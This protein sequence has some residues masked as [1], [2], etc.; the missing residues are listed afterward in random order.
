MSGMMKIFLYEVKGRKSIV[1]TIQRIHGLPMEERVHRVSDCDMKMEEFHEQN[2]GGSNVFF[3]DFCKHR[4]SGPGRAK[5]DEKT[6]G[7]DLADDEAFGEMTAALYDPETH[8]VVVQY[9]HYGPRA[10]GIADYF[11]MFQQDDRVVFEPRIRDDISAEIDKK[12]YN[13][14]MSFSYSTAA[15]TKDHDVLGVGAA[16]EAL[17]LLG[18]NVAEVEII[19]KKGRGKAPKMQDQGSFM[20]LFRRLSTGDNALFKSAKVHGAMTEEDKSEFLDILNAKVSDERDG[21][22]K[23][24]ETQMYSFQSRCELL[25]KSFAAWKSSGII[26]PD[27]LR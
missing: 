3:M 8:F 4:T 27:A 26:T 12:Q 18:K 17:G 16:L 24:K 14:S 2:R 10:G 20:R 22:V 19:V 5:A 25:G 15:L 7:F 21:L 1:D 13:R 6:K 11:S 9:N 23:D